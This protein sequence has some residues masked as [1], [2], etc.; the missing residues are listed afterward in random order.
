M[1][2]GVN[3]QNIKRS[4]Y[5]RRASFLS[6]LIL[7]IAFLG[8][9]HLTIKAVYPNP[10]FWLI[11]A[12]AITVIGVCWL[13]LQRDDFGFLL[14]V[15]TCV[16]F[17][18]AENQGGLWAYAIC[19]VLSSAYILKHRLR[20]ALNVVP[21]G[22][23]IL[24]SFFIAHQI[25]GT[26]FNPYSFSENIQATIVAAS[27]ILI[28]YYCASQKIDEKSLKRMIG[29]WFTIACWQVLI[30]LNQRYS[31][32]SLSSPL[33]PGRE[34]RYGIDNSIPTGGFG[35]S[36][37]FAEYFCFIFIFALTITI[38]LKDMKS[39]R[40]NIIYP[41]V[42]I[43]LSLGIIIM[44]GS[45]A[46]VILVGVAV[47]YLVF[48]DLIIIPTVRHF[49]RFT[50][51]LIVILITCSLCFSL[52]A[53]FFID[54]MIEDFELLNP[55]EMNIDSI[56]SGESINRYSTYSLAYQRFREKSWWLGFGYNMPGNNRISMGLKDKGP[57]VWQPADFH[58]LYLSLPIFYGWGG[59][60]AFLLI[61]IFTAGRVYRC[62]LRTRR[63]R[64]FLIPISLSLSVVWAVFLLDQY[65]ISITRN[66]SYFLFIWMLLGWTNAVVNS[67]YNRFN[68]KV[69]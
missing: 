19:A 12:C 24:L 69:R 39:L 53:V 52:G 11:G 20:I 58:S 14:V 49:R 4:L 56:F 7:A 67:I 28:F 8:S 54:S 18:F 55:V 22:F 2:P 68:Q 65:K 66:P 1:N 10:V 41:F 47:F 51:G 45:R 59:A 16:H 48:V 33:L 13:V 32:F 9:A 42:M 37:L 21:K 60:V 23:G 35:N 40:I 29:I 64:H 44:S 34:I 63:F 17:N 5:S 50:K 43:I 27:Q 62:Y 25:L 61:V 15:F 31:V 30:G 57:H 38:H 26:L 6:L 46:A 36:E 3:I